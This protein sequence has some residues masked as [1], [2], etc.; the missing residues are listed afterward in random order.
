MM[1]FGNMTLKDYLFM[2]ERSVD[3]LGHKKETDMYYSKHS[4]NIF[5]FLKTL[6]RVQQSSE[7]NNPGKC[8]AGFRDSMFLR[9]LV[10]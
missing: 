6:L 4:D 2:K 5:S 7:D 10:S 3:F 8:A 1:S 9:C